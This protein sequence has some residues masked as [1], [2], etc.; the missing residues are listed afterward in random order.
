MSAATAVHRRLHRSLFLRWFFKCVNVGPVRDSNNPCDRY[1]EW[2]SNRLAAPTS[3]LGGPPGASQ[4]SSQQSVPGVPQQRITAH[5]GTAQDGTAPSLAQS[6]RPG[7]EGPVH[8]AKR[9]QGSAVPI[10]H[11]GGPMH[12]CA[13]RDQMRP[14]RWPCGS[15]CFCPSQK[16]HRSS[17]LCAAMAGA[18]WVWCFRSSTQRPMRVLIETPQ[19]LDMSPCLG[20]WPHG[21]W[22]A[23]QTCIHV[24]IHAS[25]CNN[26]LRQ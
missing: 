1:F 23:V 22:H 14:L 17:V 26:G 5:R 24:I 21:R 25:P 9:L 4:L 13:S 19:V 12:G 6:K 20:R 15:T 16:T 7:F 10:R 8:D 3:P 18:A 2:A 11:D